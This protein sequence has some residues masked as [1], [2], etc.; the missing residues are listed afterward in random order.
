MKGATQFAQ[1]AAGLPVFSSTPEKG[2]DLAYMAGPTGG[3]RLRFFFTEGWLADWVWHWIPLFPASTGLV[4]LW[5]IYALNLAWPGNL[6]SWGTLVLYVGSWLFL[7]TA[8]PKL[9]SL[10]VIA[11]RSNSM[12]RG[13]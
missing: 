12:L 5:A 13:P 11:H 2:N 6:I 3:F 7:L 1:D 9:A 10:T 8:V 4:G